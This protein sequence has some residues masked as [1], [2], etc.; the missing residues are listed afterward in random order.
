MRTVAVIGR[1]RGIFFEYAK[2]LGAYDIN[3]S[4]TSFTLNNIKYRFFPLSQQDRLRGY[5][6]SGYRVLG[7]VDAD[8][9]QFLDF[10]NNVVAPAMAG[11]KDVL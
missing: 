5:R 3:L 6:L 11:E 8:S 10:Y 7:D 1:S 4:D 9:K 2:S